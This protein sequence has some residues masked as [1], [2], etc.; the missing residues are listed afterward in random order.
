MVAALLAVTIGGIGV[1]STRVAHYEIK[2]IEISAGEGAGAPLRPAGAPLKSPPGA[3]ALHYYLEHGS[4]S[5]VQPTIEAIAKQAHSNAILFDASRRI[6]AA[7]FHPANVNLSADGTLMF[8]TLIRGGRIRQAIAGPHDV[9]RD[10]NG[11][12]AGYLFIVPLPENNL[13][14]TRSLDRSFFWIFSGAALFGIVMA[15]LIARWVTV[16]IERL[17]GAARRME[18]GDLTVRVDPAGGPELS[19]L[20][21][22][23]NSMAAALDRNEELRRRMVTDVAHELRAPLTN[24]RSELESIQ[25]GLSTPTR[26]RIDSLHQETMHLARLVDDLQDLALAEA[27]RLEIHPERVSVATLVRRSTAGMQITTDGPEDLMVM[28]DPTRAVQILTNLLTNAVTHGDGARVVWKKQDDEA[29]IQVIDRGAGIPAEELTRI[30]ERFYRVDPSRSRHT[31]GAGLGLSIVKQL[32]AAHGG[33]V[34]AESV[35]GEGSTF[36]FTLPVA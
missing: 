5:G 6:V 27:G 11:N 31:G 16:P 20:A 22:G 28:A 34:W 26:E 32:V 29:L 35:V 24:I 33:R 4:W 30:F 25:D 12:I 18:H 9:I 23:F 19:E 1:I 36:S 8:D 3:A 10:R 17:T 14:T 21:R 13:P 2:K 15:V 7:T